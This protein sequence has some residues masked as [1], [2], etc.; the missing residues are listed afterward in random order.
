MTGDS[1][2]AA[3]HLESRPQGQR[4]P[5]M[6]GVTVAAEHVDEPVGGQV[7]HARGDALVQQ[8]RGRHLG[9]R[10]ERAKLAK[11][12]PQ[13]LAQVALGVGDER[14]QAVLAQRPHGVGRAPV[15]RA[16][17]RLEQDPASPAAQGH[18]A[19]VV[20]GQIVDDRLRH[21]AAGQHAHGEAVPLQLGVDLGDALGQLG[22]AHV[23]V[24]ADVGRGADRLDAVALRLAGH[25][26]A[27]GQVGR[28]VVDAR[29]GCGSAG[30]GSGRRYQW[31]CSAL[32]PRSW[33]SIQRR[34]FSSY[35]GGRTPAS[36]SA[37]SRER[38]A[39]V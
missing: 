11:P 22:D 21:L 37:A 3:E 17:G 25:P 16:G 24:G 28:A 4:A 12:R 29:E 1:L 39:S 36:D 2:D 5:A 19:Q 10:A 34:R 13:V 6:R 33:A 30:R 31:T 27:V 15:Q 20:R 7:E 9:Q 23:V 8:E 35:S 38:R 18:R 26:D 32:S 14:A